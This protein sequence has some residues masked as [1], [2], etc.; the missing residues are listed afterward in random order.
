[1]RNGQYGTC[2]IDGCHRLEYK[3]GLCEHCYYVAIGMIHDKKLSWEQMP[4][5]HNRYNLNWMGLVRVATKRVQQQMYSR[6]RQ[7]QF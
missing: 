5:N 2:L 7:C 6:R 3:R 4:P 1:M